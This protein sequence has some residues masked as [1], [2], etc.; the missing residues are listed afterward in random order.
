M[1]DPLP[2]GEGAGRHALP[3]VLLHD[4]RT[5]LG[6]IIG[7]AEMLAEQAEEA[8]GEGQ[9]ADLHK[10]GAAGY[11][12]LELIE[13]HF[14]ALP[15][16]ADEPV[17]S[18]NGRGPGHALQRRLAPGRAPGAVRLA[19]FIVANREPILAEW[20]AFARTCTPASGAMDIVA[21]RDHANEMLTVIAADLRTPQ[22]G[23]AQ[24]EKGKGK[25]PDG[26]SDA[27]TAAE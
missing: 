9:A 4:L 5:P 23:S 14:H 17:P 27:P 2:A 10:I 21:L 11:R 3:A 1:T 8:G 20:E 24:S 22:G 16:R 6:Q 19:D 25:A 15:T 26:E 13:E 12:I 7:Y 18:P